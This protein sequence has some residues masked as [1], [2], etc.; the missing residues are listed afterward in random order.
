MNPTCSSAAR[1]WGLRPLG[2]LAVCALLCACSTSSLLDS[3]IPVPTRYVLAP[4]PPAHDPQ[5]SA[6]SQVDLAIGRPDVAPGLDTARIAVLRGRKLDYYRGVQWSGNMLE[7]VQAFLVSSLQD[8]GLFRSV[9]AEQARVAGAYILDTEVR[10][11]QAE[12]G[13]PRTAPT[14]RVTIIGRLIRIRD[15]ALIATLRASATRD[16]TDNHMRAVAEAFEGAA[17]E[18]VLRLA[19]ETADAIDG[20]RE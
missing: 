4:L 3:D 14:V 8:Q 17:H 13:Q 20:D 7:V 11:F 6:A 2:A 12:Y 5:T 1:L 9:T 19:Q 16:A 10:D 15:R 18:V